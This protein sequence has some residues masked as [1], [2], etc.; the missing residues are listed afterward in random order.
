MDGNYAAVLDRLR[1]EQMVQKFVLKFLDDDSYGLLCRS[2][3]AGEY[4]EAFRAVH[5]IKGICQNLGFC[6]LQFSSSR[7]M[8]AL[9]SG[10]TPEVPALMEEV[11][12]DY[13]FTMAAIQTYQAELKA[14]EEVVG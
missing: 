8:E 9:R 12:R 13:R 11:E 14:S 1:S 2:L 5:T 7:L 3:E 4:G 10:W 6:R